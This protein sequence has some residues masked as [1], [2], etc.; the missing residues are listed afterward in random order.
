[1]KSFIVKCAAF[2]F[3][4]LTIGCDKTFDVAARRKLHAIF[5]RIAQP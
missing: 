1:M 3:I 5:K 2:C 4:G